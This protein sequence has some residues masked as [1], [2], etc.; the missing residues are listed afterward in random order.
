VPDPWAVLGLGP[1]SSLAEARA[2]RRRLAKQLHP[3][4]HTTR[5]PV[6]RAELA[7][8]MTQ[9]NLAIA[10]LE[11]G[12]TDAPGQPAD[13][14][15]HPAAVALDADSFTVG[16][17]PVDAFEAVFLAGYDLGEILV[18]DEPYALGLYLPDPTPCFC[19][20]LLVPEAGGSIVT[21][22]LTPA[23]GAG[24]PDVAAV[25]DLLVSELNRLT[26]LG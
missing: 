11:A 7:R 25:R 8:R 23:E 6:E 21:L 19:H 26:G 2:A 17:R 5:P 18:D 1:G 4:L 14:G 22:D 24:P 9:V 3:D 15:S 13:P 16:A 10:E 12:G 20:L